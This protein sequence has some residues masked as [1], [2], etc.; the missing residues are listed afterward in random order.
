M[1]VSQILCA[2]GPVDAVTN[3][4]FACRTLF[5]RWGWDG[6]DYAPVLAAGLPRGAV[7][8]LRELRPRS[9]EV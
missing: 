6:A 7:N 4:G 9:D 8:H 5:K 3:Q 2:A 1:R